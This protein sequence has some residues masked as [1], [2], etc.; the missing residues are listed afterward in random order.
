MF[1]CIL[2]SI[3]LKILY[4]IKRKIGPLEKCHTKKCC[5]KTEPLHSIKF[6]PF[7]N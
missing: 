7:P 3:D 4:L 5:I 1:G 2:N 6:L